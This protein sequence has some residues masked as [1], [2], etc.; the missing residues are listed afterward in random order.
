MEERSQ[1]VPLGVI[2]TFGPGPGPAAPQD[3]EEPCASEDEHEER[4]Q[5]EDHRM[6]S[7]DRLQQDELAISL[8][9]VVTN[10]GIA[11]AR[12][13]AIP[14][15]KPQIFRKRGIGFVDRLVLADKAAQPGGNVPSPML[16]GP[17][18]QHL[19]RLNGKGRGEKNRDGKRREEKNGRE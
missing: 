5:P 10:L 17:I 6:W 8:H 3:D 16:Q 2:Q 7:E 12:R 1:G 11:V 18:L 13:Q 9:D 4:G 19:I 14:H 15:E